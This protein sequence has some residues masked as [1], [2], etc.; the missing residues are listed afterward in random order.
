MG[1]IPGT[2]LS[3]MLTVGGG[4]VAAESGPAAAQHHWAGHVLLGMGIGL[5]LTTVI[6]AAARLVLARSAAAARKAQTLPAAGHHAV[7]TALPLRPASVVPIRGR[8]AA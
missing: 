5:L 4:V 1:V 2:S 7:V 3:L 8:H 6:R